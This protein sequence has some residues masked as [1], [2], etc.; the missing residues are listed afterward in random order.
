MS[1]SEN[2]TNMEDLVKDNQV[3]Q[4]FSLIHKVLENAFLFHHSKLQD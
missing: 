1:I 2:I 3:L 4:Y